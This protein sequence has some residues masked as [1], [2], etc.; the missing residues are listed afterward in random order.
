MYYIGIDFGHGETTVSRVP[1]YNREVVSQIALKNTNHSADKKIIS[2]IYQ[3]EGYWAF[4]G[5]IGDPDLRKGFKGRVSKM[6]ERDRESMREFA[7]L[8]FNKILEQN[9]DELDYKSIEDKNFVLGIACPSGWE[10]EDPNAQNEYLEFFR[11]ECGLPVDLCIKESDAAFFSKF[12]RYRENVDEN[13]FVID[14]GSST[15]DF[16]AYSNGKCVQSWGNTELGAH[17]IEDLLLADIKRIEKNKKSIEKLEEY[18]ASI[19]YGSCEEGLSL[20]ARIQKEYFFTN[21]RNIIINLPFGEVVSKLP[22]DKR[23][24]TCIMYQIDRDEF[25]HMINSYM[26][27]LYQELN[28]AKERL[29]QHG[30]LPTKVLLSGGACRMPFIQKY[31]RDIFGCRVDIDP[32]PECVVSNGIALYAQAQDESWKDVEDSLNKVNFEDLYIEADRN[33]THEVAKKLFPKVFKEIEKQ[34]EI[35]CSEIYNKIVD[36][37]LGLNSYNVEYVKSFNSSLN[38][39]LNDKIYN[40]IYSALEKKF[41]IKIEKSDVNIIVSAQILSYPREYFLPEHNGHFIIYDLLKKAT[42]PHIFSPFDELKNRDKN[43]KYHIKRLC[44]EKLC[45]GDPFGIGYNNEHLKEATNSIKE[46]CLLE[47]KKIFISK[48]L[49]QTTFKCHE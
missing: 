25:N 27:S 13:V 38:S 49:F 34:E 32:Q 17:I 35:N 41:N 10:K 21:E 19:G 1:G 36:F 2:A 6:S 37:F 48:Q 8:V 9:K 39:Y 28:N 44:E 26:V 12:D 24:E 40:Y 23:L 14:L 20:W 18:R 11:N 22:K 42:G 33:A 43:E 5:G 29:D 31:T 15:I 46:Q 45:V 16:T 47:A 4:M 30:I 3:Y 7:K